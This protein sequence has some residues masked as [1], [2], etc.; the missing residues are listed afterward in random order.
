[1]VGHVDGVAVYGEIPVLEDW[2]PDQDLDQF[3]D[4]SHLLVRIDAANGEAVTHA[5][6]SSDAV[7]HSINS[8]VLRWKMDHVFTV[9]DDD[10]RLIQIF[11]LLVDLADLSFLIDGIV[12]TLLNLFIK[13][14]SHQLYRL[15]ISS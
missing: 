5:R 12:Y 13:L 6:A 14:A 3:V 2:L 7:R 9:F 11:D 15:T 1:M 4:V 8:A 10:Q